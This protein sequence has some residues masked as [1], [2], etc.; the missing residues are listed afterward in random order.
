MMKQKPPCGEDC[1]NRAPGCHGKCEKYL[2]YRAEIDAKRP[3]L[4]ANADA[5]DYTRRVKRKIALRRM[6][7]TRRNRKKQGGD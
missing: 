7:N 2:S 3:Q 4:Y 1:P 5:D 6:S